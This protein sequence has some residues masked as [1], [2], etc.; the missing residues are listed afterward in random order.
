MIQYPLLQLAVNTHA[1]TRGS[2]RYNLQLTR[3]RAKAVKSYLA[4]QGVKSRRMEARAY[5][6]STPAVICSTLACSE[7][8]HQK[9]RRAEF[10]LAISRKKNLQPL[11]ITKSQAVVMKPSAKARVSAN[12]AAL[13]AKYGNRQMEGL[14]FKVCV[15]AYRLNPTLTFPAFADL[16]TVERQETDG[17]HYYYL[18]SFQSLQAAEDVRQQVIMRGVSDAYIVIFYKDSKISFSRFVSIT[19]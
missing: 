3:R 5:G 10:E 4:E 1:D 13:L 9:N 11:P 6:K 17:I 14:V 2:A 12:Y 8:Q 18:Q 16:G 19:E 15:G 7:E